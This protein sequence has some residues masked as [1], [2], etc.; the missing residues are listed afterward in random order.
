MIHHTR[1]ILIKNCTDFD[2]ISGNI[3]KINVLWNVYL[4]KWFLLVQLFEK[5]YAVIFKYLLARKVILVSF[6]RLHCAKVIYIRS[7][8][9]ALH[10]FARILSLYLVTT[11]RDI[12][13]AAFYIYRTRPHSTQE[14]EREKRETRERSQLTHDW[15]LS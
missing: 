11:L 13:D 3:S 14:S 1:N 2:N 12:Y 15:L 6:L 5:Y 7:A 10:I 4:L 9:Y 8:R